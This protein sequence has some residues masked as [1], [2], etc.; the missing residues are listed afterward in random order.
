VATD[1]FDARRKFVRVVELR[2]DG[3][4]EFEF[5]IGE[6]ELFVEMILP[7]PAFDDFCAHNRVSFIGEQQR[8]PVD[9]NWDW[10]L[11]DATHKR[12]R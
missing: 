6:P 2:P 12:F 5:A 3:F 1:E 11:H 9:E 8:A 10:R 7:A 4:V